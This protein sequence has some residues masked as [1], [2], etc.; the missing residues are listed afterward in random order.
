MSAGKKIAALIL[1]AGKPSADRDAEPKKE[2]LADRIRGM[3]GDE[4][5]EVS[6]ET[7]DI[8]ALYDE[9]AGDIYDAVQS[10]DRDRA[11]E[12]IASALRSLCEAMSDG[13]SDSY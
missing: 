13:K 8:D 12:D 11:V 4:K 9:V 7:G 2:S 1:A 10:T 3:R 6:E 5:P